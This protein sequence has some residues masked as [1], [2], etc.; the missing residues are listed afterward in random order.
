MRRT[1]AT[2]HEIF[3]EPK[4]FRDALMTRTAELLQQ[5]AGDDVTQPDGDGSVLMTLRSNRGGVDVHKRVRVHI[6]Q[7]VEGEDVLRIP[8]RWRADPAPHLFPTFDGVIELLTLGNGRCELSLVGYYEPPLGP[9]GDAVDTY[10]SDT[11]RASAIRLVRHLA[12]E[13]VEDVYD[14]DRPLQSDPSRAALTVRDVMSP[15]LVVVSEGESLRD[16]AGVLLAAGHGGVPVVDARNQVIGVLSERDLL[17]RVA[18]ER[19][20]LGPAAHRAW[21][22]WSA[23]NAGEACSKPAVTTE[24]DTSVRQ[25]ATLM[26]TRDVARLVVMDGA[27]VVGIVTRSDMLRVLVRDDEEISAAV[28]AVLAD[29]GEDGVRHTVEDGRVHLSGTVKLRSRVTPVCREVERCDGVLLVDG[30]QLGWATDDVTP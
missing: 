23:R 22:R 20:G 12:R 5:A 21:K 26:A 6:D 11:A 9:I 7:G 16:A 4:R 27:R 13:L 15:E 1:L 18:D 28:T 29:R 8:V 17:D 24:A 30:S 3:G 2:S 19:L 14:L 10:L 25:A